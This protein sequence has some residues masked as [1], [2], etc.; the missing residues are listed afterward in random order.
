MDSY[1]SY[2]D[3][4]PRSPGDRGW[5]LR[6]EVRGKDDRSDSFYRNRSPGSFNPHGAFVHVMFSSQ[7]RLWP[8]LHQGVKRFFP[9]FVDIDLP[10]L[11]CM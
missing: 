1:S 5:G 9:Q 6:E 10:Y 3:N 8:T 2:R 7:S 4:P 11:A